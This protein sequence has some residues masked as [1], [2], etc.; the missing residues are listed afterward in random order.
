MQDAVSMILAILNRIL[1][2]GKGQGPTG[3]SADSRGETQDAPARQSSGDGPT[4]SVHSTEAM[5]TDLPTSPVS[6]SG[7]VAMET[8]GQAGPAGEVQEGKHRSH[9]LLCIFDIHARVKGVGLVRT[10]HDCKVQSI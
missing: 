3:S 2:L 4:T 6:A 7:P 8:E 5:N 9:V 10:L 1:E